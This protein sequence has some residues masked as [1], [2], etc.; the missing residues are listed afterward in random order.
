[1]VC[2]WPRVYL[3]GHCTCFFTLKN[4]SLIFLRKGQIGE[5]WGVQQKVKT[6]HRWTDKKNQNGPL[7]N[8]TIVLVGLHLCQIKELKV[9]KALGERTCDTIIWSHDVRI[10]SKEYA[11]WQS[12]A[13][14][15]STAKMVKTWIWNAK[16]M[17]TW[18]QNTT[19]KRNYNK[20]LLFQ[21]SEWM[22]IYMHD[23]D[24]WQKVWN[25]QIDLND[26]SKQYMQ[27]NRYAL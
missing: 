22:Y 10:V 20:E 11:F 19:L 12:Y 9:E 14:R 26:K 4:E 6:N 25:M 23:I 27:I 24:V 21:I 5:K 8:L 15:S 7:F 13:Y 16:Y 17:D 3:Y 1:M 18:K 2:G